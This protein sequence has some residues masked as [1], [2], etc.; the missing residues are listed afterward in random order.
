M[1]R[2]H[3][4][5]IFFLHFSIC[6][7]QPY[8]KQIFSYSI[9][10]LCSATDLTMAAP[11]V[12]RH[13]DDEIFD[14]FD[15]DLKKCTCH[16]IGCVD[17]YLRSAVMQIVEIYCCKKTTCISKE[18]VDKKV[19]KFPSLLYWSQSIKVRS[20]FCTLN[21]TRVYYMCSG[22]AWNLSLEMEEMNHV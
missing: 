13:T 9:S 22:F 1:E 7:Q 17:S 15:G 12:H 8:E 18:W 21:T 2:I 16:T 20:D 14:F 6:H 11:L 4:P 5:T 19:N 3:H 10:F